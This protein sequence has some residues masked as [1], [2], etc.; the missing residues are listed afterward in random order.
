MLINVW[1]NEQEQQVAKN[2]CLLELQT[3]LALPI[4][5]CVFAVN[6]QIIAQ[7]L[8]AETYIN[9]GDRIALFQAIAGG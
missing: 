2:S 1:I 8:W 7:S 3:Q 9:E 6:G 4:T 5:G